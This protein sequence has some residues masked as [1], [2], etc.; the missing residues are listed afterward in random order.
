MAVLAHSFTMSSLCAP[1]VEG[2]AVDVLTGQVLFV[3][4]LNLTIDECREA[5][6]EWL[7]EQGQEG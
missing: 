5:Y 6:A 4:R 1:W 3:T 7:D 2:E